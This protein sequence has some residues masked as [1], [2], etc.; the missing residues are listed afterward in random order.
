MGAVGFDLAEIAWTKDG[1]AQQKRFVLEMIDLAQ[2]RHRWETLSYEAAFAPEQLVE[3]RALVERWS[4]EHV[5]DEVW[6]LRLPTAK[7]K[8]CEHHHVYMHG[9]G[10]LICHDIG[11]CP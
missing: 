11:P 3:L 8:M 10:C 5:D 9:E 7:P 1:F 4:V 2:G 6:T